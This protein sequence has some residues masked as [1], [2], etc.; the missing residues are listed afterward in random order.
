MIRASEILIE[1]EDRNY[2]IRVSMD[3][4]P[5]VFLV[6]WDEAWLYITRSELLDILQAMDRLQAEAKK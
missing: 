1:H 2:A 3:D 5:D 6:K 4:Q